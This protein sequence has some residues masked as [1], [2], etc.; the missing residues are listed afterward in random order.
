MDASLA[1]SFATGPPDTPQDLESGPNKLAAVARRAGKQKEPREV[2]RRRRRRRRRPAWW[3]S[4]IPL[5]GYVGYTVTFAHFAAT[6]LASLL[7]RQAHR[8]SGPD[9]GRRCGRAEAGGLD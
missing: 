5:I 7:R 8:G 9:G 2:A 1:L 6:T 3:A 4:W